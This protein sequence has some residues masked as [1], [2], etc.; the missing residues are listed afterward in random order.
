[1][2][3][4]MKKVCDDNTL[5]ELAVSS[6]NQLK[7][8]IKSWHLGIRA[9]PVASKE[10]QSICSAGIKAQKVYINVN[11]LATKR[12]GAEETDKLMDVQ[13]FSLFN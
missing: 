8:A 4:I 13:E 2:E 7:A 6:S 9:Y 3:N 1:M 10:Y 11:A 12:F 5:R